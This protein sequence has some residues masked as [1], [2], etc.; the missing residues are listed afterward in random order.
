M[1]IRY[2]FAMQIANTKLCHAALFISYVSA[3]SPPPPPQLNEIYQYQL[4]KEK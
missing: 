4:Y 3:P 2:I 1:F